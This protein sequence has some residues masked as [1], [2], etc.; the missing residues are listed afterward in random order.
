MLGSPHPTPVCDSLLYLC[1]PRRLYP[2]ILQP[3][4]ERPTLLSSPDLWGWKVQ[5]GDAVQPPITRGQD[6]WGE[7]RSA[8]AQPRP[9]AR[10]GA[11]PADAA[12]A[13]PL[14]GPI[15]YSD[16]TAVSGQIPGI[17]SPALP[18]R[19]AAPGRG[20]G[21]SQAGGRP[22]PESPRPGSR[23]SA[24]GGTRSWVPEPAQGPP[25][26]VGVGASPRPCPLRLT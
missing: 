20:P 21:F 17:P 12:E 24:V 25:R 16:A 9:A 23:A 13:L 14:H 3:Y 18:G 22:G 8:R 6:A 11:F 26:G 10:A 2:S 15:L 4:S 19:A 5:G 1:P 7:T